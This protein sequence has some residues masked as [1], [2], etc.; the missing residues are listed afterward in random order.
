MPAHFA[1]YPYRSH[2]IGARPEFNQRGLRIESR[3]Y[4]VKRK[5]VGRKLGAKESILKYAS[6]AALHE[7]KCGGSVIALQKKFDQRVVNIALIGQKIRLQARELQLRTQAF[8]PLDS[9]T[10]FR[11]R[12]CRLAVLQCD[13]AQRVYRFPLLFHCAQLVCFRQAPQ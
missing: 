4:G 12:R 1:R 6:A 11:F 8:N 9:V 5:S 7:L 13:L 10:E 2:A 3:L